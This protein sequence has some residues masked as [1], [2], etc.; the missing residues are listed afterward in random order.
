MKKRLFLIL[1]M[2]FQAESLVLQA[3][4][5]TDL[6]K[7]RAATSE[8]TPAIAA[9][10]LICLRSVFQGIVCPTYLD[11][12]TLENREKVWNNIFARDDTKAV[13]LVAVDEH[14]QPIGCAVAGRS[15]DSN[16]AY[17]AEL[18]AIYVL[19]H[20]QKQKIGTWLLHTVIS[21][22]LKNNVCTLYLWVIEQNSACI[23]YE[24]LHAQTLNIRQRASFGDG[25]LVEKAYG[26]DNLETLLNKICKR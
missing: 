1:F 11:S 23:F 7:I 3:P 9:I 8:D 20:Y 19:P 13:R 14:N 25:H 24:K 12:L 6:I 22:L 5:V 21:E 10:Q 17:D 15:R 2:V 26:W 18:Y 16:I 4:N